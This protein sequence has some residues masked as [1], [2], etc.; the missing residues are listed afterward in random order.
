[1]GVQS[2][3]GRLLPLVGIR[4]NCVDVALDDGIRLASGLEVDFHR[5]TRL[6]P[7]LNARQL[8]V[9]PSQVV[10]SNRGDEPF[11]Q[12]SI[13][14]RQEGIDLPGRRDG[15]NL[16]AEVAGDDGSE[17]GKENVRRRLATRLPQVVS[18]EIPRHLEYEPLEALAFAVRVQVDSLETPRPDQRRASGV[19]G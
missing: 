3:G 17:L 2:V 14:G 9:L 7:L 15:P 18:C 8:D 5:R 4:H 13:P 11:H 6:T 16:L 1:M 12:P 19:A 10:R